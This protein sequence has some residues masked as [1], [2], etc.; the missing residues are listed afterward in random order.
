MPDQFGRVVGENQIEA[1]LSAQ[2]WTIIHP[3]RES[4]RRSAEFFHEAEVVS[5][6]IGS[7]FHTLLLHAAP[8]ARLRP[9]I[10]PGIPLDDYRMVAQAKQLV[11]QPIEFAMTALD[12]RASWTNF[13]LEAPADLARILT[14]A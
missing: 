8:R 9:V 7:A 6:F 4:M 14:E 5:G 11:F 3:E 10:R 13:R 1:L 2:G 12:Q